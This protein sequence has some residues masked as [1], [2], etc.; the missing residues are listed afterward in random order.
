MEIKYHIPRDTT[1]KIFY[2]SVTET[3]GQGDSI[4]SRVV[5]PWPQW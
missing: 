4:T 2:L 1:N 3:H 5:L